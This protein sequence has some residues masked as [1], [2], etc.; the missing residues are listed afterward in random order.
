MDQEAKRFCKRC[1]LKDSDPETYAQS[2][3]SYLASLSPEEKSP[4]PLY[5]ERLTHCQTCPQ[6]IQG[7]CRVCGCFV[8]VRAA[9]TKQYCPDIQPKW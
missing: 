5:R 7:M 8:E 9:K 4:D 6:L 3:L 1:L 2:I